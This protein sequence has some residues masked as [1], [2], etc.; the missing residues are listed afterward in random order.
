MNKN[1]VDRFFENAFRLVV[2]VVRTTVDNE[3]EY[4]A[5]V[6][7]PGD[8]DLNVDDYIVSK[9][10]YIDWEDVTEQYDIRNQE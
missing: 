1:L 6:I 7:H 3:N 8:E 2:F 4:I 5:R 10:E 9:F